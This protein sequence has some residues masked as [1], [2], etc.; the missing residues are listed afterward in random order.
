MTS[1]AVFDLKLG[2]CPAPVGHKR[3]TD[4]DGHLLCFHDGEPREAD[5]AS[6]FAGSEI[7]D[8]A[9]PLAGEAPF[10]YVVGFPVPLDDEREFDDWYTTEHI[11]LLRQHPSWQRCRLFRGSGASGLTRLAVHEWRD[12][13]PQ[14][15]PEQAAARAT[16]WRARLAEREWFGRGFRVLLTEAS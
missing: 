8:V 4:G 11:G 15:S 14:G 16:P 10:V 6:F 12:S 2:E 13:S 7:M 1:V 3:L 5:A 9:R